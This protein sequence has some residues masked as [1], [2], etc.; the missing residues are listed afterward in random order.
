MNVVIV[1]AVLALVLFGAAYVTRRRFGLLGLALAAG[2][3]LSTMWDSTAGLLVS[4]TGLVPKGPLTDAVTLSLLVLL[5]PVVLLFHGTTYK[6]VPT[7]LVGS[8]LFA[9]LALAFLVVPL[10]HA[11][12]LTGFGAQAYEWLDSN[13]EII[14]SIGLILAV[15]DLFFTKPASH[16]E[17]KARH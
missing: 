13:R 10:G 4:A 2:S 7:R 8:F 17:K 9:I 14:I 6:S 15:I 1:F 3:L 11:L 5:P 16:L 12:P